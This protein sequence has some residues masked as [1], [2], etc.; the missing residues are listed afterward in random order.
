MKLRAFLTTTAFSL[1]TLSM[2][3]TLNAGEIGYRIAREPQTCPSRSEPT[4]GAIS[5][6]QAKIYFTCGSEGI[7]GSGASTLVKT[8]SDLK[9]QVASRPRRATLPD[10]MRAANLSVPIAL[11]ES[12]PVYDIR[13]SFKLYH[14]FP[15]KSDSYC[16]LYVFP[17]S[18]GICFQNSFDDWYCAMQGS[19]KIYDRVE[20]PQ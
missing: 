1:S 15:R 6:K 3:N 13:G 9:L 12:K 14:C 4:S 2:P 10:V 7:V 8:V 18:Q 20:L 17:A 16:I 11:N 5:V 19:A